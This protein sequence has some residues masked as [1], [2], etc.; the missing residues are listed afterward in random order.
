MAICTSTRS[1]ETGRP[2]FCT[3]SVIPTQAHN[4]S[5]QHGHI[6]IG[7]L[8][9]D[10]FVADVLGAAGKLQRAQ[11]LLSAHLAWT[12]IGYD[13]GLGVPAQRILHTN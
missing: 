13:H 12:D 8:V 5:L 1:A 2:N 6:T 7:V 4:L 9:D 10:R 3:I 11:R